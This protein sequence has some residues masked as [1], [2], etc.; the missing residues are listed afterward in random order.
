MEGFPSARF[1]SVPD[2]ARR[3]GKCGIRFV[4]NSC[5][6]FGDGCA[7]SAPDGIW[8]NI[9][10]FPDIY[11]FFQEKQCKKGGHLGKK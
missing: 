7:V 4:E 5:R 6:Q 8:V 2:G 3:K 10:F 1:F 9:V 11:T